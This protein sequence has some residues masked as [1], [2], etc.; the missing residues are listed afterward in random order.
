MIIYNNLIII[1][2]LLIL[3]YTINLTFIYYFVYFHSINI[4]DTRKWM[5]TFWS[6][7]STR[8]KFEVT[9]SLLITKYILILFIFIHND[10]NY[11]P[12][13]LEINTSPSLQASSRFD[14]ILLKEWKY[15]Y[16]NN[17]YII[18]FIF[19]FITNYYNRLDYRVK[20]SML[21]DL[22]NMIG[23]SPADK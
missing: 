15:E 21:T 2:L 1:V 9:F 10:F 16:N 22:F 8:W 14:L 20:K 13:I 3:Q 4:F 17:Y 6:R 11:R 23:F 19:L 12:W 7:Y 5:G 18:Y